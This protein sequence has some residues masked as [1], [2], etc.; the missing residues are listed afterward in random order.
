MELIELRSPPPLCSEPGRELGEHDKL[1][2]NAL[3][4]IIGEARRKPS[5]IELQTF[6]SD[7][8][9]FVN[10]RPL[11]SVSSHPD[12]LLL[13]SGLL[14]FYDPT[15]LLLST[16]PFQRMRA[17]QNH[18]ASKTGQLQRPGAEVV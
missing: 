5:S 3:E 12:D 15:P 8:V 11:T 16:D 14:K 13:I 7:A 10:E 6:V 9:R 4:R 1:F 18:R 2:K 17:Q